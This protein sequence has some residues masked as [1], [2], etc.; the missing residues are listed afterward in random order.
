MELGVSRGSSQALPLLF[1]CKFSR[2]RPDLAGTLL[3]SSR[4][5]N[6]SSLPG[7]RDIQ[8]PVNE[9]PPYLQ[10]PVHCKG[11]FCDNS[12]PKR[13]FILSYVKEPISPLFPGLAM[14]LPYLVPL[15]D[16]KSLLVLHKSIFAS[17]ITGGFIFNVNTFKI[18]G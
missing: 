8:N 14:V 18:K 17:K 1:N 5:R 11:L 15:L 7:N 12:P 13:A 10:L 16:C 3:S 9:K 4:R 6:A 2:K